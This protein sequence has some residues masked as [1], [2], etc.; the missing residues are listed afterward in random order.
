VSDELA[1]LFMLKEK[2]AITE[3]EYNTRKARLLAQ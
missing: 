2:G 1:K 3:Q